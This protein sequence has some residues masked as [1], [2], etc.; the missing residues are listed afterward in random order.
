M[1]QIKHIR[2]IQEDE[3][4]EIIREE[5][6]KALAEKRTSNKKP[7]SIDYDPG[8]ILVSIGVNRKN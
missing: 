2:C 3:M 1:D 5:I 6:A 4:R 7:V 8:D